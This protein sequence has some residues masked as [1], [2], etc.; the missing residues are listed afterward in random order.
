MS[1]E[2]PTS[3]TL[4]APGD[5]DW[6]SRVEA[7][8]VVDDPDAVPWDDT[9]E[10]V[11]V[12][13]GG[14]GV[15]AALQARELGADVLCVD[16]AGGG[17]AT[18]ISGGVVYAGGTRFQ[19]ANG[20]DDTPEAMF[21]YLGLETDGC[22]SDATL[23]RFCAQSN[24]NLTWLEGHGVPF[25]GSLCPVK[26]SYPTNRHY[27]YYSGNEAIDTYAAVA[28]PAPRGHRAKGRGLPGAA[29]YAPLQRAAA[30][31]GV[32][33]LTRAT[34]RRLVVDGGGR[35]VG[36]EVDVVAGAWA[37]W[38]HR[39]WWNL[40]SRVKNYA[41]SL[42]RTCTQRCERLERTASTPRRLRATRGVVLAA[43]G[44]IYNRRMVADL[45]P[46]YRPGMPLGTPACDGS[47]IRLGQSVGAA[48]DRMGVV[49]AWRFINPPLAWAKGIFVDKAGQRYCNEAVYGAKL[50]RHMV[51]EHGGVGILIV[52][53]A[54]RREAFRQLGPGQA[55]WFQQAP[56]VLNMLANSR[57]A[58]TIDALAQAIKV[59]ADALRATLDA[60]NAAASAGTPDP[61]GKAD[62]FRQAMPTGPFHAMDCGIASKRFPCPTLTLGGLVVDEATGA[63]RRGDGSTIPGLFAAGRTA[64][65]VSSNNYVSGLSIADC[66]FSGRRAGRS[67]AGG[68]AG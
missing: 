28:K 9:A 65:G 1:R 55:Q 10:V 58:P 56:G 47:G 34:A 49:S 30:A 44:F 43:G 36:V 15:C 2:A 59:P 14:A 16:R 11:V 23:Q 7:P 25:E 12:G 45:A 13:F 29:L 6:H 35:V 22:V 33:S 52:D 42:A 19:Q 24:A 53:D 21:R 37:R 32:R 38:R 41:P 40:A 3:S 66:V 46:A 62:D 17:G 57:S 64:V 8:R 20:Y 67:A 54:L 18:A 48:V 5:P 60:Y 50:G 39:F 4:P 27:L 63:V 51:E 26:T 68:D 31:A 61:F